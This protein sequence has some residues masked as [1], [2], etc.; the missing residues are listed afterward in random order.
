MINLYRKISKLLLA[1]SK[2]NTVGVIVLVVIGILFALQMHNLNESN[3][4]KT[5]ETKILKELRSD[6]TQNLSEIESNI[7]YF[8]SCKEANE[9]IINHME[10]RLLYH[11]SLDYHFAYLYPYTIFCPN[12]TTF[13]YIKQTGL[14][15]ISNDS[16]RTSI[17]NLYAYQFV[18]YRIFENTYFVEHYTN[19][20]KPM[21]MAEF[22]TFEYYKSFKPKKYHQFITNQK[23]KPIM[24]YTIDASRSFI[25]MLSTL[26]EEVEKIIL[27]IDKEV[28][29]SIN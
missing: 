17:S 18:S 24:R 8:S 2:L 15:L 25:F 3:K 26:K 13:D 10:N 22:E 9:I 1:E 6:L 12:Q 29:N 27:N 20:I 19:Y 16:L 4:T 23:Y 5:L 21:F 28:I 14:F 7:E 11:D